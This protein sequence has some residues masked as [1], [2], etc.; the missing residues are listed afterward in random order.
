MRGRSEVTAVVY[1]NHPR[2]ALVCQVNGSAHPDL[3]RHGPGGAAGIKRGRCRPLLQGDDFR[4]RLHETRA[5]F[6]R[7]GRHAGDPVGKHAARVGFH[8]HVGD[9]VGPVLRHAGRM[10]HA[11][12]E[13]AHA[14]DWHALTNGGLREVSAHGL[15]AIDALIASPRTRTPVRSSSCGA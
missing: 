5:D 13:R 9:Q 8:K 6:S 12:G 3:G 2:R 10:H 4:I 15:A 11:R 14:I 1:T 7:I